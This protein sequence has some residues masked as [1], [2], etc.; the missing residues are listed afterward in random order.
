M[1]A[2]PF[3]VREPLILVSIGQT[4]RDGA[5]VYELARFAWKVTAERARR[6]DLVLAQSGGIVRGAFRPDEWLAA[7]SENFPGRGDEPG[8]WGFVGRDAEP[9]VAGYY[10]GKRVPERYRPRG[11]ANPVRYCDP[12]QSARS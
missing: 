3:E 5:D 12:E 11:A 6:Y 1:N 8:R 10:I 9:E 2:E 7:T 4:Y